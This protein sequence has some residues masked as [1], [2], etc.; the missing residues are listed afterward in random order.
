MTTFRSEDMLVG[1]I[2]FG[3]VLWIGWTIRRGLRDR[4]LPIGRAYV[5]R[6]ERPGA[7]R[8]LLAFYTIGAIAMT[9]VSLN[10]LLGINP[11]SAS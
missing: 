2:A 7:F 1:L 3:A 6:D 4:R 8:V 9:W 10:L 11:R 5:S